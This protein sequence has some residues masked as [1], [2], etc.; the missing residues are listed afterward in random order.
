M[1]FASIWVL[2]SMKILSL[3]LSS[4]N[5]NMMVIGQKRCHRATHVFWIAIL[6]EVS[7]GR[8]CCGNCRSVVAAHV[9]VVCFSVYGPGSFS[10]FLC[11]AWCEWQATSTANS[12][13]SF[14]VFFPFFL[15]VTFASSF[16]FWS[17]IWVS[18]CSVRF[19]L[20]HSGL[21]VIG[22]REF[23]V[24]H[25]KRQSC[26]LSICSNQIPSC[27][28]LKFIMH[29]VQSLSLKLR[30]NY[31]SSHRRLLLFSYFKEW[32]SL[33]IIGIVLC[34]LMQHERLSVQWAPLLIIL[35][36]INPRMILCFLRW[37]DSVAL[38]L[39]GLLTIS[40]MVCL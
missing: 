2:W 17:L 5:C 13:Y 30:S 4:D 10:F 1:I 24:P 33:H 27:F 8:P 38:E 39:L 35:V 22:P 12:F 40:L 25:R 20:L 26:Q 37:W 7:R 31:T 29:P 21:L 28:L 15:V 9:C 23:L 14:L 16:H 3:V 19:D 36:L 6:S 18:S 11:C 34:L 32:E